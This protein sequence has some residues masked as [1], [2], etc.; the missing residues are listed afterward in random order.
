MKFLSRYDSRLFRMISAD[1][2]TSLVL[3]GEKPLPTN[4]VNYT[5]NHLFW[6]IILKVTNK[7]QNYSIQC[8]LFQI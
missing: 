2:D 8:Y 4:A 6:Y 7:Q 1:T 5:G 3:F